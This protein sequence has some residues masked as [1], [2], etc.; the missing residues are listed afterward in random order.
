MLSAATLQGAAVVTQD[1]DLWFE[2][3]GG[4]KLQKILK[5]LDVIY[6]PPSIQNPP[7][8]A[9]KNLGLFDI[10]VNME[11]LGDFAAEWKHSVEI[12]L[13]RFKVRVLSL[14]RII[15]S[16]QTANRPKN[17][18]TLPILQDAL[19]AIQKKTALPR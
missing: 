16:K 15:K 10:V 12:P 5:K 13:G 1:I 17:R 18:L 9:G 3:L 7:L 2:D 4:P 14:E 11:S 6:I 8:F 19:L